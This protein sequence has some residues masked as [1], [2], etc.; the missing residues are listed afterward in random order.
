MKQQGTLPSILAT[1]EVARQ[2]L[3]YHV[4]VRAASSDRSINVTTG[5]YSFTNIAVGTYAPTVFN[6]NA[7][8]VPILHPSLRASNSRLPEIV[9]LDVHEG[10]VPQG[11]VRT[12]W[13][14]RCSR[15]GCDSATRDLRPPARRR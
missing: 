10:I 13:E 12:G 2:P 6:Y 9:A 5:S 4:Y 14:C 1:S 3:P 11:L 15:Y 7:C 8:G